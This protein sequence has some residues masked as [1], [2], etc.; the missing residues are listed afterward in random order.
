MARQTP[1]HSGYTIVNGSGSGTN[2]NR[3]D[4]W[5]EY[6]IGSYD[7]ANNTTPFTAYFYAALNP[8]YSSTTSNTTGLNSVFEV[9][10]AAGTTVK[11]GSYD[12]RTSSKVNLLGSYNGN[13]AHDS[14]GT[15]TI[16]ISGSFTTLSN[17]ISGGSVDE[18]EVNLPTIPRASTIASAGNVILGNKCSIVW[19]PLAASFRYKLRFELG[20]WH[21]TTG[22]IYPNKTT[23][24]TYSDYTLP[25]DVANQMPNDT[26]GTMEVTLYTYSDSGATAQVGVADS[27]SFTVY[28]PDND[29]TKPT[30]S[31]DGLTPVTALSSPF[32]KIF[33]QGKCK[34]Q[35]SYTGTGQY[36]ADVKA[37][38]VSIG[39][40]TSEATGVFTSDYLGEFGNITVKVTA[41]DSRGFSNSVTGTIEVVAYGKPKVVTADDE[42]EVICARCDAEG[43]LTDT[44]TSLKVK[45]KRSYNKVESGGQQNNYCALW[46]RWKI[47]SEPDSGYSDPEDLISKASTN[48]TY[49]GIIDSVVFDK[50]ASYTIQLGVKDD[51]GES[52]STTFTILSEKVYW[53]RGDGF[54]ALGMHSST[55]G[56]E[57]AWP[58]TFYGDIH[59]G[60]IS[61]EDYI[62]NIINEGG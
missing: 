24:Y 60:E 45:V 40:K 3:I 8:S 28:V 54:L 41:V 53:H 16:K 48:D 7:V 21:Y 38:S 37:Y 26:E 31:I 34:V 58:S 44:G 32:D 47:A 42:S 23:A 18:F 59:V 35:V 61:L 12:F 6:K 2:G 9:N 49:D 19:T 36:G 11:N 33:V 20:D 4:V 22:A 5:V 29:S 27:E 25:L 43:N 56:F 39:G 17:W 1:V 50:A 10:G 62:R 15:K 55:G 30:V 13:I 57:V 14:D 51:V 52:A 46:F